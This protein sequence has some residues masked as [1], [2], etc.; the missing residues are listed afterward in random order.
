MHCSTEIV[1]GDWDI[2]TQIDCQFGECAP[3]TQ[4]RK[5]RLITI[6]KEYS[7]T[8]FVDD[9]SVISLDRPVEINGTSHMV[10]IH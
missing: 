6:P 4:I 5:P 2:S 1:L 9:I 7:S 10:N 3:P 8:R